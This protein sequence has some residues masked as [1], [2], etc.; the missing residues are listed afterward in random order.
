MLLLGSQLSVLSAP[1]VLK[2]GTLAPIGSSYHKIFMG[3]AE[4]WKKES[5]GSVEVKLYAGGKAGSEAEMV[6]LVMENSLQIAVLTAGGLGEID[7]ATRGL[8]ALP[9]AFR[10]LDEVDYVGER[11]QPML[12]EILLQ[13]G[14]VVLF[15]SDVGWVRFFSNKPV[16]VPD[17]LRKLRL[18]TWSGDTEQME[19]VKSAGFN[20]VPIETADIVPSLQTGLIDAVPMPPFFAL[21][22]QVDRRASYMLDLNYAPLVGACVISKKTWESLPAEQRKVLMASSRAIGK[23]MKI[24]GRRESSDAVAAMVKRG[25]KVTQPTPGAIE[26]WRK[27]SEAQ[28]PKIRGRMMPADVF[29]KAM[30]SLKEFRAK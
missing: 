14:F 28:Y 12:E 21:A 19:I 23:D 30:E 6:G 27:M 24:A 8:Q 25:L 13:K 15:W 20:L 2:M 11:L 1:T 9:M 5:G 18:F 26:E 17:D 7:K 3:L 10:S 4:T 29:D 16:L 22:S